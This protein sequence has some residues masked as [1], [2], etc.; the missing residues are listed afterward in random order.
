MS[1][2]LT[3]T[4]SP[5]LIASEIEIIKHQTR[6]ILLHSSVEIGRRLIEAK[7]ML[8][9]GEWG[10]WLKESVD[11]S[12][13][14]A[15]N[16]MQIHREYG[17]NPQT[18]G[19]L[20]YTQA[21]ALIGLPAEDRETFVQ[22]NDVESMSTRELQQAV[23]EKQA[24]KEQLEAA[25]MQADK[26]RQAAEE[27]ASKYTDLEQKNKTHDELVKQLQAKL[28]EAESSQ[29]LSTNDQE[30][31]D[32]QEQLETS[33]SELDNSKDR[34]KE[35]ETELRQKPIDIDVAVIKEVP[36]EV[37]RELETLRKKVAQP[38]SETTIR[39]QLTFDALTKSFQDLLASLHDVETNDPDVAPK[40]RQAVIGLM[41]KMQERL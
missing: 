9:H 29:V 40:Y 6:T 36:E 20:S 33:Q 8:P 26:D 10:N 18:F 5:Q 23:K 7:E 35:L 17:S 21:I 2:Q 28:K 41:N 4:R 19:N 3:E 22:N 34:I 14:T 15:N 30:I 24:L 25:Q 12:Q 38:S 31:A 1:N 27:L 13:S 39:F 32:L 37:Q 16:L 11:Y